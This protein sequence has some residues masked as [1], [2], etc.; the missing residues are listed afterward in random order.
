MTVAFEA[1]LA[2]RQ[3]LLLQDGQTLLSLPLDRGG[4]Y[5]LVV[6]DMASIDAAVVALEAL[7]DVA[8][9]PADGGLLGAMS[10][11]ANLSLAL[12]YGREPDTFKLSE[13]EHKLQL[14]F[15]LCGVSEDRLPGLGREQPMR[16]DRM[17]RWR[18]GFVLQLMRPSELLVLDRAFNGL[19]RGQAEVVI[20]LESVYHEFHP[21][22]PTLFVDLDA[23]GLPDLPQCHATAVLGAESPE[24]QTCPS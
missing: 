8:V 3:V 20:A 11:S 22:R 16:L 12:R 13:W 21:F 18:V 15:R 7:P 24:V 5:R 10:V 2:H 23:H 9:L 1:R 14:A 19:S 4:R 6:P 17:E